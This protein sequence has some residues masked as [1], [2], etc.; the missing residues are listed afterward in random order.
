M[1]D[2][3]KPRSDIRI[4]TWCRLSGE[5]DQ[6]SHIDVAERRLVRGWRF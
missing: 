1:G 2:R 4:V 3:G 6:K 5:S